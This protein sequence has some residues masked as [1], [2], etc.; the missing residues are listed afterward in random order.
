MVTAYHMMF[1]YIVILGVSEV[2]KQVWDLSDQDNDGMLSLKEFCTA[3]YLMERY[4]E[5]CPLPTMLPSTIM[6]DEALFSTTSQP[7]APHSSGTWGP[8]A[9][10]D[11][12]MVAQSFSIICY[13]LPL[14]V[15]YSSVKKSKL[16]IRCAT[17]SCF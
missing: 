12:L 5:G 9:G 7:Q 4:R 1:I 10:K 15:I 17:T 16:L 8:V 3:L 13:T 14:L 11:D 2:L 6:P